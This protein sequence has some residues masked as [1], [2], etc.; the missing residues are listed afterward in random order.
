MGTTAQIVA[1]SGTPEW[2]EARKTGIGASEIA[3]AAG[4]NPY[5]TPLE[6]YLRKR[7]EI[8]EVE[9]NDYMRMGRLLEPVVKA[10]YCHRFG[11]EL[12]DPSPPMYRHGMLGHI[13]ATPDG[14]ITPTRGLE[15]K[16]AS[17]RMKREY[18]AEGSDD[19]PENY[20][21]QC[22]AQMAVM[23]FSEVDLAVLFDGAHLKCFKVLRNEDLIRLLLGAA[24]ELWQ[25]ICD[26]RPPEPDWEHS[27]TPRLIRELHSTIKD[28]RIWLTDE[29]VDL[30]SQYEKWGKVKS[31]A[32]KHQKILKARLEHAIGD[33]GAGVLPDGRMIRRKTIAAQSYWVD[34]EPYIDVRAVKYDGGPILERF[35]NL[36]TGVTDE[37]TPSSH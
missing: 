9:D 33:H 25:R 3:T 21:C 4:L 24:T 11:V 12:I 19:A 26:G 32:D 15:A 29:E 10:E 8:G 31:E 23:G 13:L 35:D 28:T 22:Q 20:V 5:Q 34:K 18:G 16:T 27:S 30:W 37:S 2:Y 36:T 7:G 14:V 17:W 6:L 1:P